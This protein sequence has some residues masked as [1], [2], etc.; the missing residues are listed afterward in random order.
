MQTRPPIPR[1]ILIGV[2]I[3]GVDGVAHAASLEE[4]GRLVKTL[5]YEVV[6]TISQ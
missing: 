3:P 4:L 5:G 2:Q 1:A 6:G